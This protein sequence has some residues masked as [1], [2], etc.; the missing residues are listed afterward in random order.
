MNIELK[1][2]PYCKRKAELI[3]GNEM[4]DTSMVHKIKCSYLNCLTIE[5]AFSGWQPNY[6]EL[7][8]KMKNDW[9]TIVDALNNK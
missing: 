4:S 6:K 8:N 7:V 3:I 1:D 2:C 5:Q 9:N